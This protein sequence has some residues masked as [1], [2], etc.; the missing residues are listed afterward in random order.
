MIESAVFAWV[1]RRCGR[2]SERGLIVPVD[3]PLWP[4]GQPPPNKTRRQTAHSPLHFL[5][6]CTMET[7]HVTW[8]CPGAGK[9]HSGS[10]MFSRRGDKTGVPLEHAVVC[11]HTSNYVN[12][13]P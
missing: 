2:S 8:P 6:P 12:R 13:C 11:G 5:L 4:W 10:G 1:S 9:A 3:R 7:D